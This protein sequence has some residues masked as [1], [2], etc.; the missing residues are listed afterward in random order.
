MNKTALQVLRATNPTLAS[1]PVVDY[2]VHP[3]N[4]TGFFHDIFGAPI[5][6]GKLDDTFSHMDDQRVAF[7]AAFILSEAFEILEKGLGLKVSVSVQSD[8][9]GT[10][11]LHHATGSD[12]AMLTTAILGAMLDRGPAGRNVVEVVDG[13]SDLNVVV[14]GWALELGADMRACDQEVLASNLTK[15]DEEGKPIVADGSDPKYPAGKILK[16]PNYVEPNI[17]AVLGL[18]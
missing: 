6:T 1:N 4:R 16:G 11:E 8:L 13:L 7:R 17:A 3:Q 18:D 9:P 12:N 15:L 5:H 2:D 10:Q 14:N